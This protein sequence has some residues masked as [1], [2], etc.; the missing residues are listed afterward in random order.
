MGDPPAV[1]PLRTQLQRSVCS[2]ATTLS[3]VRPIKHTGRKC[4][5][6]GRAF[7]LFGARRLSRRPTHRG[8]RRAIFLAVATILL[9][10]AANS[11]PAVG[12]SSSGSVEISVSVAPGYKVLAIEASDGASVQPDV[13]SARLCLATNSSSP[14]MPVML[15]RPSARR[16]EL[17]EPASDVNMQPADGTALGIRPCGL[18][19]DSSASRAFDPADLRTNQMLLVHPE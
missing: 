2:L 18:T 13:H 8:G 4:R 15:V 3:V 19:D 6:A 5:H 14:T 12:S 11:S 7:A 10:A 9:P 1:V 17:R 16:P